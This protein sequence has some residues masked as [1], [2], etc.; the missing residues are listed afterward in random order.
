[1]EY[2]DAIQ[3]LSEK[4]QYVEDPVVQDGNLISSRGPATVYHYTFKIAENLVEIEKV[5]TMSRL[6]LF[7]DLYP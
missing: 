3:R 4:Y 1:M 5:R 7:T 6:N 2:P